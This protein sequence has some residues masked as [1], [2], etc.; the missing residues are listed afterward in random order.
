MKK[1]FNINFLFLVLI[2]ISIIGLINSNLYSQNKNKVRIQ[3][4]YFKIMDSVSYLDIKAISKI[5]KKNTT[6]SNIKI[7]VFNVKECTNC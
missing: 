6:V 5:G 1:T 4:Y 3:A 7:S 2:G